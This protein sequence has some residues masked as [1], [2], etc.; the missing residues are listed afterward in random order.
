MPMSFATALIVGVTS[1]RDLDAVQLPALRAQLVE[2]LTRLQDDFPELPLVMLSQFVAKVAVEVLFTPLTY[3]IVNA[4]KR[5]E[6]ED[7]YDRNTNFN[8]FA[9]KA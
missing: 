2:A 4:L 1:H 9:L 8:P 7:H 3:K 6:Q 5:A